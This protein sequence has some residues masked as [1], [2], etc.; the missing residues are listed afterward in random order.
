MILL[1]RD[2]SS[3]SV[4]ALYIFRSRVEPIETEN[5]R[6]IGSNPVRTHAARDAWLKLVDS[7]R[8]FVSI[9]K[10]SRGVSG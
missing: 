10:R 9:A 1:I 5:T 4:S 7:D 3:L 2:V 8:R 6:A